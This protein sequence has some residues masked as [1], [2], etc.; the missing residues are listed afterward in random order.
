MSLSKYPAALDDA[1]N[2]P[3]RVPFVDL[4][5]AA[6]IN[7][8]QDAIKAIEAEI[9]SSPSGNL[10]T[11]KD[12]LSGVIDENGKLIP[13]FPGN[14]ITVG[15]DHCHFTSIQSA[16]DSITDASA[17]N[18][19]ILMIY[20]STYT[21][22]ISLKSYISLFGHSKF[23]TIIEG[24]VTPT[25]HNVI[26][27][28]SIRKDLPTD[29]LLDLSPSFDVTFYNVRIHNT[30]SNGGC[31]IN[32]GSGS[33]H[34]FY[35]SDLISDNDEEASYYPYYTNK[36]TA[37]FYHCTLQ[38]S[39]THCVHFGPNSY[40]QPNF[41]YC[42]FADG[43][44]NMYWESGASPNPLILFSYFLSEGDEIFYAES[45]AYMRLAS[46]VIANH[47]DYYLHNV[48]NSAM[49]P[50]IASTYEA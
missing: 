29:Y 17:S 36:T 50:L 12:R 1:S 26:A 30:S 14:V 48:T 2:M 23:N 47:P 40:G 16:I 18:P 31:V 28:L 33:G 15:P 37:N 20:P 34:I 46:S 41:F 24:K 35:Y 11:L 13:Y 10:A 6:H 22:D 9:G 42:N 43:Y 5:E 38:S 4:Y 7:L 21:E 3:D 44:Q 49:T 45:S 39:S 25:S 32:T 19:Y 27:N 8:V